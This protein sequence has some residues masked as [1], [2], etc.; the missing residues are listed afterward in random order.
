MDPL[1]RDLGIDEAKWWR[2]EGTSKGLKIEN[3]DDEDEDE[4]DEDDDDDD[5]EEEEEED[6]QDDDDDDDDDGRQNPEI[7]K[8]RKKWEQRHAKNH[9]IL[10]FYAP[11]STLHILVDPSRW[12]WIIWTLISNTIETQVS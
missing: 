3:H 9:P 1:R 5:D 11:H 8:T 6:D 7:K 2:F 10:T 12:A 4:D